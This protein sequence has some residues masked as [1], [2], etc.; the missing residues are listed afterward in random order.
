MARPH[1]VIIGSGFGGLFAAQ[2]LAKTEVDVT[3]IS[4]TVAHLFQPLLYQVATGIL[5][6]GEIAPATRD[7]LRNQANA[8]VLLAEVTRIN[9]ASRVVVAEKLRQDHRCEVRLPPGR[10]RGRAVLLRER[11]VRDVRPRHEEHRRCARTAG[12]D[13]RVAWRWPS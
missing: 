12:P 6:T 13:L 4:K 1:V 9:L 2:A 8:T 7:I 5:S 11:P 3:I 10:R